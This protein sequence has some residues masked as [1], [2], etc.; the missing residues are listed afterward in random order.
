MLAICPY[1]WGQ[2]VHA[3]IIVV[4]WSRGTVISRLG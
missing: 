4:P 2:A 3:A 1:G